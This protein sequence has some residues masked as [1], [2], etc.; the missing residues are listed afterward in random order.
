MSV[1]LSNISIQ[2]ANVRLLLVHKKDSPGSGPLWM[3]LHGVES[4]DTEILQSIG[5]KTGSGSLLCPVRNASK[6]KAIVVQFPDLESGISNSDPLKENTCR[7]RSSDGGDLQI[8]LPGAYQEY[9]LITFLELLYGKRLPKLPLSIKRTR[10][11]DGDP[12]VSGWNVVTQYQLNTLIL[13]AQSGDVFEIT[14]VRPS[15]KKGGSRG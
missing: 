1:K 13:T 15:P 4:K 12:V 5:I 9:G 10:T 11:V 3:E 2:P 7:L 8:K 14:K 6:G